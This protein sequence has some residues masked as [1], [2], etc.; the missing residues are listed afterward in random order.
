MTP[1]PLHPEEEKRLAA[2]RRLG[3]L[4]TDPEPAFDRVTRI[5]QRLF[6]APISLVSLVDRDRQW[7]KSRRG[8]SV[9]ETPRDAS[10]CAHA[11]LGD[12]VMVVPDAA[13]D[14][15]FADNPLVVDD[16]DI[17]FYAGAPLR[18]HDGLPIGTLCVIDTQPRDWSPEDSAALAD[19]A[20]IVEHEL[21]HRR[22]VGEHHALL[23]LT[24]VTALDESDQQDLLH[25]ALTIGCEYLELPVGVVS[26][27]VGE[28]YE[29]LAQVSPASMLA[30]GQVFALRETYCQMALDAGQLLAVA[31]M[32][33]SNRAGEPCYL[34]T[35]IEAY[36]GVPLV[37]G[38]ETFGTVSFSGPE[39]HRSSTFASDE[40][41]FVRLL[42]RWLE[43]AISRKLQAERL[44]ENRRLLRAITVAQSTFIQNQDRKRAFDELLEDVLKLT[45]CEYGFIG[46]V[47]HDDDGA[48]YLKTRALTNIAWNEATA[49]LYREQNEAGLEFRNLDTLFGRTLSTGEPVIAN[50]P[51]DDPRRG[52]LPAEHPPMNSYLGLPLHIGDHF[53]GMLGLA[54]HEGG[55]DRS[56]VETLQPLTST[57]AQL[58]QAYRTQVE[59]RADQAALTRLSQV[60]SQMTNAIVITD[61]DGRVEWTNEAFT[62]LFGYHLDDVAGLRP[63]DI[64][65]GP[66]SDPHASLS[67]YQAMERQ[68]PF[69]IEQIVADR[70]GMAKWVEV[71]GTPLLDPEGLIAGYIVVITDISERK[72]VER[73]KTE[74]ISTISH[75][76]RT[77]LT[78][79]AG[80]LGLVAGGVAGPL[81][82]RAQHMVAIAQKN[83]ER[84]STLINDLLDLEKLVAG[85]LPI[86]AEPHDVMPIVEQ[87]IRDNEGYATTHRTHFVIGSTADGAQV[88]VDSLRLVQVLSNLLSNAAKFSPEGADVG[89]DIEAAEGAV[90]ISVADRGPGIDLAF[91]DRVFEKFSQADGSDARS[92][93]GSGL[94]LAISKELMERMG[95]T[96][97]FDSE[98][99]AGSVFYITLPLHDPSPASPETLVDH[100]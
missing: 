52:G 62:Q 59:R 98:P 32:G 58:I 5:S 40:V 75:E 25:R 30:D 39:P 11:I 70:E 90:R 63:R 65:L 38:G 22:A 44:S 80:S 55:F 83:S 81:P 96:I 19:L 10:F 28:R 41:D 31:H 100:E 3:I 13:Q 93:G 33:V 16:P 12:G 99:G 56:W 61:L 43:G 84:L 47:L 79:I 95:G 92:R 57:I 72:R 29:I 46:E 50:N 15:R 21:T 64:L 7:F 24:A 1:A 67:T 87:A 49:R 69:S 77:P 8:L 37:V 73:M 36:I 34:A 18:N 53:V 45:G 85:G 60:A 86:L 4:D 20:T 42:G 26:R 54:N 9:S 66:M 82:E 78:S 2:L 14:P 71:T 89:I 6:E 51:Y 17:R 48:P 74:F 23:T 68:E 35:G 94:G 97:G 88:L 27:I 76:L 91:H